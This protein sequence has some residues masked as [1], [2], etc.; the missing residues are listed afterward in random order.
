M[1]V[2][3]CFL[4][5]KTLGPGAQSALRALA[6][7]NMKIGR[8]GMFAIYLDCPM[9]H[10]NVSFTHVHDHRG[11]YSHTVRQYQE[12]GWTQRK[13]SLNSASIIY[14]HMSIYILLL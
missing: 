12:K 5:T 4:R 1:N 3:T 14:S 2:N 10:H 6:R 11:C 8:I 7:A 13:T 9:I